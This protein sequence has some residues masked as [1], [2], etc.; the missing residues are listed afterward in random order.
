M[1]AAKTARSSGKSKARVSKTMGGY[2]VTVTGKRSNPL[3]KRKKKM[4]SGHKKL[5]AW[6]R[7]QLKK[8]PASLSG[9]KWIKFSKGP[10]GK[11][12]ITAKK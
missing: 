4:D 11:T 2:Q 1:R 12:R 10:D 8:N 9:F 6:V 3:S 5:A 7:S